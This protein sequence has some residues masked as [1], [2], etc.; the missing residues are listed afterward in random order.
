MRSS[1]SQRSRHSTAPS[2]RDRIAKAGQSAKQTTSA[3]SSVAA[4]RNLEDAARNGRPAVLDAAWR[5]QVDAVRQL[6]MSGANIK[7]RDEDGNTALALAAAAG[8]VDVVDVLIGRQGRRQ[9]WQPL[10]GAAADA[11]SCEGTRGCCRRA[12]WPADPMS[13]PASA[14][15]ETALT[16][17]VRGCH[18]QAAIKLLGMVVPRRVSFSKAV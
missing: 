15:G 5:G 1:F 8:K 12:F 6:I 17:A 2:R 16:V 13:L 9:G 7:A 11:R 4:Q 10:R 14:S 18:E 3:R